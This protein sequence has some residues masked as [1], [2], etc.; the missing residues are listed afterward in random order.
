MKPLCFAFFML[1]LVEEVTSQSAMDIVCRTEEAYRSL[2]NYSEQGQ[3]VNYIYSGYYPQENKFDY[4][5]A[6]DRTGNIVHWIN[7]YDQWGNPTGYDYK[8]LAGDSVGLFIRKFKPLDTTWYRPDVAGGALLAV[9]GG[10][11]FLSNSLFYDTMLSPYQGD[12]SMLQQYDE[13][14]RLQDTVWMGDSCYV[15]Q[16]KIDFK[17]T[18]EQ[19]DRTNRFRDST[20]SALPMP[21]DSSLFRP[22]KAGISTHI[23][24]YIIRKNDYLIV[25]WERSLLNP[26]GIRSRQTAVTN[27]IANDSD[28]KR[29]LISE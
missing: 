27:P 4:T 12:A 22:V 20:L 13:I 17:V 19:V 29:F 15:L 25:Y 2:A 14:Q 6:L 28:F 18:Q 10:L 26:N 23:S 24:R 9:G 11:L 7:R 21:V 3:H 5:T 16:S 1:L 8:R